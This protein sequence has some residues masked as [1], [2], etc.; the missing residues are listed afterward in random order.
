MWVLYVT[1][2]KLRWMLPFWTIKWKVKFNL[3]EIFQPKLY[4]NQAKFVLCTDAV[5]VV[6][7]YCPRVVNINEFNK[8]IY[9]NIELLKRILFCL[10]LTY[11]EYGLVIFMTVK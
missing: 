4:A 2:E 1:H 7:F 9:R 6:I 3:A 5:M 10:K 11:N 8:Y